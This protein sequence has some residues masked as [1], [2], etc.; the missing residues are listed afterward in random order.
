MIG[1]GN[2]PIETDSEGRFTIEV[3]IG[4]HHIKVKS[5]VMSSNIK[6]D[7]QKIDTLSVNGETEIVNTLL[8]SMKIKMKRLFLLTIQK[9][10]M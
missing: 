9:S 2:N 8:I 1:S 10:L 6:G 7:F 5:M 4:E 3:P